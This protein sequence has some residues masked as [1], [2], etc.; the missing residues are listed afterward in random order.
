M[1]LNLYEYFVLAAWFALCACT[2]L[3]VLYIC[4]KNF[5]WVTGTHMHIFAL[6]SS[7]EVIYVFAVKLAPKGMFIHEFASI[8]ATII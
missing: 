8:Y 2:I 1:T 4:E 5:S 7:P 6:A 3:S